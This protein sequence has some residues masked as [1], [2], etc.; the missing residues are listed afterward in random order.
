MARGALQISSSYPWAPAPF[1]FSE[2]WSISQRIR[3][4][5][6][7]RQNVRDGAVVDGWTTVQRLRFQFAATYWLPKIR[8]GRLFLQVSNEVL[9]NAGRNAG[10]NYLDQNRISGMFGWRHRGLQIRTGYMNRFVPG[11]Q[12]L[13][14]VHEHVGLLWVNQDIW[15]PRGK[16]PEPRR[17]PPAEGANP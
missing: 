8:F 1:R 2:R 3:W 9:I 15:L 4:D 7:I 5:V 10:P 6:R 14:P 11:A 12:G 17:P 13:S 16:T